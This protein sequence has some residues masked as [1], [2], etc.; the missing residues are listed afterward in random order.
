MKLWNISKLIWS[1]ATKNHKEILKPTKLPLF[2]LQNLNT[3]FHFNQEEDELD[4]ELEEDELEEDEL[5]EEELESE[6]ESEEEDELEDEELDDEL[7]EDHLVFS[8]E[9]LAWKIS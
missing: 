9:S 5:E 1:K 2:N 4:D 7:D 8:S 3:K 6:S